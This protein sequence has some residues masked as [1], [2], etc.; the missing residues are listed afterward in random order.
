MGKLVVSTNVSLDGVVQDPDGADGSPAGNW[1]ADH[2]GDLAEWRRLGFEETRRADALLLGR[3]TDA[4]FASRW[5]TRQG[6]W[7]DAMNSLP[8]YVVS[9]TG[10]PAAWTNAT[11]LEGEISA[12]VGALKAAVDGEILVYGSGQLARAL[13]AHDLVDEVRLFI[14]PVLLGSGARLFGASDVP[15]GLRLLSV[16]A[17]GEGLVFVRYAGSATPAP[18]EPIRRS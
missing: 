2:G 6:E 13:L 3:R 15:Q 8:K 14:F 4:W 1:F 12:A 9:S 5:T 17:V 10:E 18:V 7:A 11:V 16:E